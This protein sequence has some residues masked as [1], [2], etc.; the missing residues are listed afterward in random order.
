MLGVFAPSE[1]GL[2]C[3]DDGVDA[4]R[5]CA[6]VVSTT[7]PG[8]L[9][10]QVAGRADGDG[11]SHGVASRSCWR[12]VPPT[13]SRS[14]PMPLRFFLR[15]IAIRARGSRAHQQFLQAAAL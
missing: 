13:N 2:D 10:A 1:F 8:E 4:G 6:L 9:A 11:I 7:Q 3:L 14:R 12:S 15:A 5:D